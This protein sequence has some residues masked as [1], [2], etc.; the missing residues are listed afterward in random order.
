MI[1]SLQWHEIFYRILNR[2]AEIVLRS[3]DDGELWRFLEAIYNAKVPDFTAPLHISWL[4]SGDSVADLS[5]TVPSKFG[6]PA[7]PENVSLKGGTTDH[8]LGD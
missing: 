1:S 7:I 2:A 4:S 5:F 3:K 8:I 6:L